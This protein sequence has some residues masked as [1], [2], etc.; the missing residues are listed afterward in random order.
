MDFRPFFIT[1]RVA[2]LA[3]I[4]TFFLGLLAANFVYKMKRGKGIVDAIFTPQ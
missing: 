4:V 2:I 1:I 3:T